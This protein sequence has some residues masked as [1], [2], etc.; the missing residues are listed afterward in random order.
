MQIEFQDSFKDLVIHSFDRL[1]NVLN[2]K[3]KAIKTCRQQR[4]DYEEKWRQC[5]MTKHKNTRSTNMLHKFEFYFE[6]QNLELMDGECDLSVLSVSSSSSSTKRSAQSPPQLGI[7]SQLQDIE[8]EKEI[9]SDS[10]SISNS[11][12]E[13]ESI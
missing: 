10:H 3:L 9:G 7:Q 13:E 5:Q 1:Q 4:E 12:K 8:E 2:L 6:P 11:S